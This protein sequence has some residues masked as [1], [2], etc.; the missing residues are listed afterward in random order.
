VLLLVFATGRRRS[1]RDY[2]LQDRLALKL[3]HVRHAESIAD[4]GVELLRLQADKKAQNYGDSFAPYRQSRKEIRGVRSSATSH[5]THKD[6]GFRF[7]SG[8]LDFSGFR[9]PERSN[10]RSA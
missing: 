8:Q 5:E 9:W 2:I 1:R 6:G 10:E 4:D 7:V 3:R